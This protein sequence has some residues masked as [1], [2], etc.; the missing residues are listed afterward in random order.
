[1]AGEVTCLIP[2]IKRW[3]MKKGS[4]ATAAAVVNGAPIAPKAGLVRTPRVGSV[5]SSTWR[6][7]PGVRR[8]RYVCLE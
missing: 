1:V 2:V 6:E 4:K 5:V 3:T 8:I 7:Q